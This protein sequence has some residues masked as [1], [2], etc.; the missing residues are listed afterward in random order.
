LSLTPLVLLGLLDLSRIIVLGLAVCAL[1]SWRT[2]RASTVFLIG[3]VGNACQVPLFGMLARQGGGPTAVATTWLL[4]WLAAGIVVWRRRGSEGSRFSSRRLLLPTVGAL[5]ALAVAAFVLANDYRAGNLLDADAWVFWGLRGQ[6]IFEYG[7]ASPELW[8]VMHPDYPLLLPLLNACADFL[9]GASGEIPTLLTAYVLAFIALFSLSESLVSVAGARAAVA[10]PTLFVLAPV[11]MFAINPR[12]LLAGYAEAWSILFVALVCAYRPVSRKQP[13]SLDESVVL[14]VISLLKNEG[15][16]FAALYV[17]AR[18]F[19]QLGGAPAGAAAART[20]LFRAGLA[21]F[22][23]L[24]WLGLVRASGSGSHYDFFALPSAA[25]LGESAVALADFCRDLPWLFW[26]VPVILVLLPISGG[27]WERW[28]LFH[29][30]AFYGLLAAV[31]FSFHGSTRLVLENSFHRLHWPLLL[32]ALIAA[33]KMA[34][35][36]FRVRP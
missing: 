22:P 28:I 18:I 4:I 32:L 25:K 1:L 34:E 33:A 6:L 23:G 27:A 16:L 3:L 20:T 35:R 2:E 14:L 26:F 12:V 10:V 9:F 31:V 24:F 29:A 19:L 21:L 30:A 17:A 7:L 13:L 11:P 36:P 5:L 15:L 8:Q